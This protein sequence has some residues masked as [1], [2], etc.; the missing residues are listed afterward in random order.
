[1]HLV[2]FVNHCDFRRL[3]RRL[4]P[5][6]LLSLSTYTVHVIRLPPFVWSSFLLFLLSLS[7]Y[8]VHVIRFW[9]SVWSSF[10]FVLVSFVYIRST[11]D[12]T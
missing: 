5:L 7:P 11:C 12:P 3:L 10:L 2:R 8:A 9:P 6:F 4:S 1:M